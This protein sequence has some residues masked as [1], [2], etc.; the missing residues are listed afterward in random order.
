MQTSKQWTHHRR[1]RSAADPIDALIEESINA[2]AS[3]NVLNAIR[4]V[5]FA[6]DITQLRKKRR[7]LLALTAPPQKPTPA[8]PPPAPAPV[9]APALYRPPRVTDPLA[10]TPEEEAR[11]A[12]IRAMQMQTQRRD[13]QQ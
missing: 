2:A 12:A 9:T 13:G 6:Q 3:G 1:A 11:F 8:A 4:L 5:R 7:L 10:F